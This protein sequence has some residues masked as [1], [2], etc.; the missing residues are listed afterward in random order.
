MLGSSHS[1]GA[2]E[3]QIPQNDH[4]D[5]QRPGSP[6]AIPNIFNASTASQTGVSNRLGESSQDSRG[7]Q[8]DSLNP[9]EGP[10]RA[11]GYSL[12]LGATPGNMAKR[13]RGASD[14][15]SPDPS[16]RRYIDSV[17]RSL[18][19]TNSPRLETDGRNTSTFFVS[20]W[21]LIHLC[22][23][24]IQLVKTRDSSVARIIWF[25]TNRT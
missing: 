25:S 11:S 19:N 13:K 9:P 14:R 4:I 23:S 6:E 10:T 2:T 15:A 20:R 21:V 24:Y 5:M 16:K 17:D 22:V 8:I 18:S 1:L 12:N 7:F 3:T